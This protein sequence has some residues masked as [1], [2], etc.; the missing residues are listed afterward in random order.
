M[1]TQILYD[2]KLDTRG[3][4]QF[5][6]VI[7]SDKQGGRQVEFF[8]NHPNPDNR[9]ANVNKEVSLLGGSQ[10][11][12]KSDSSQFQ[13]IKRYVRSLPPRKTRPKVCRVTQAGTTAD[14][15][16]VNPIDHRAI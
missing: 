14:S 11:G 6:E 9:M 16:P 8:S 5:F 15:G 2:S 1:G 7:Q 4:A 12:Y 3:M 10:K 13:D